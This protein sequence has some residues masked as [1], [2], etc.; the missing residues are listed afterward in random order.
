VAVGFLGNPLSQFAVIFAEDVFDVGALGLGVL[1]ASLGVGAMLSAPLIGGYG[2][3]LP[4]GRLIQYSLILYGVSIAAF[5]IAPVYVAAVVALLFAGAGFLSVISSSNTAIQLLVDEHMR[6]RVM[7]LR[8]MSFTG[9]YPIGALAQGWLADQ[10]GPRATVTLAGALL[11]AIASALAL[12]PD[13][14]RRLDAAAPEQP[15]V[16]VPPA[17]AG[18]RAVASTA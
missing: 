7:A 18:G 5:G 8:I 15:D 9:S 10:I 13:L 14:L 16:P 1:T 11:V 3:A 6:G 12:R 4:R 2:E 17:G